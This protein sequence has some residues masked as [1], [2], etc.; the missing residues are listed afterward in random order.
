MY[1]TETLYSCKTHHK[2]PWHVLCDT[3][4]A[5]QWGLGP[6]HPKGKVRIPLLQEVLAA[7]DVHTVAVNEYEHY[8]AQE[9]LSDSG[10]TSKPFFFL[11]RRRSAGNEYVAMVTS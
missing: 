7:L 3:P 9:R 1:R 5:T 8:T 11:G 2:V 10:A 6:L 4:M